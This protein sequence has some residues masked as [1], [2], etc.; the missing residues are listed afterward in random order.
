MD[1]VSSGAVGVS[2]SD[3]RALALMGYLLLLA[4]PFTAGTTAL[5]AVALAYAR[6]PFAERFPRCH[7]VFQIRTF[8]TS[9]FF[10]VLSV[11]ASFLAVVMLSGDVM[12]AVGDQPGVLAYL[13]AAIATAFKFHPVGV[14]SLILAVVSWFVGA[15]WI[16]WG[17]VFGLRRLLADQSPKRGGVAAIVRAL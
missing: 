6:R 12:A 4:A 10:I 8:W 14:L 11:A 2:S 5:I 15:G 16:A 13:A 3:D 17:A 1:T 9:I 7:Y